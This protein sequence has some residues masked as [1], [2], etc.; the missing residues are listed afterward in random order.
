[1]KYLQNEMFRF[2][3]KH[4]YQ[5]WITYPAVKYKSSFLNFNLSELFKVI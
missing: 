4:E 3:S 1:M 2:S 5:A